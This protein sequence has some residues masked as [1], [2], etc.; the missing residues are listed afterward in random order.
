MQRGQVAHVTQRLPPGGHLALAVLP[1]LQ[2]DGAQ[3]PV[4]RRRL[5]EEPIG[6]EPLEAALDV[7]SVQGLQ[8]S[9]I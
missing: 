2:V 7:L 9:V 1:P 4:E 6:E 3:L 5:P 8:V